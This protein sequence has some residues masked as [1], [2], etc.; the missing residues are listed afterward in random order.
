MRYVVVD[1]IADGHYLVIGEVRHHF[2]YHALLFVDEAF[3]VL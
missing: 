3:R 2:L 1:F